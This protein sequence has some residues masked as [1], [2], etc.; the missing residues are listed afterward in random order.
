MKITNC[1]L[2]E[3][4]QNKLLEFFVLQVT[5]RSA[6]DILGIQPN[7]A[8]LFYRKIRM[9]ISHHLALA[10]DE[11]FEG[12]VEL[13]ESYFGGRRKGRRGRGAARKVVVFGILK[14]N[15]RVYTV[16]VD[17]AKSDTLMPV[18]KQKI[19]PDSIVYTGSLSSYDKLDVSGFI[20]CGFIHYRINHSKE[21]ADRQ[22][23]IN[24]IENFWNQAKRV[25]RKYNRIDRKSFPLFLKECEFRFNFGTPSQ[26]LKI[27]R[28]WCGI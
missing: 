28:N 16:V 5:A 26:Q 2:S 4:V 9:I 10:A 14:R 1:K 12:S 6:A 15:G 13:D 27:L 23:H 11:V 25:L 18:I 19:M 20:H 24:G 3:R 17:N 7:S 8:I 22:N 21:F